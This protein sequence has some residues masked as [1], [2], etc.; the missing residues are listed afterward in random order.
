ML[1]LL[2]N[3]LFENGKID[4]VTFFSNEKYAFCDNKGLMTNTAE[5]MVMT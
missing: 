3:P 2:K 5:R 4:F 1:Y